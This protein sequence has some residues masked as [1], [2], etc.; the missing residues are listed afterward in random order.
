[1]L[2]KGKSVLKPFKTVR[3]SKKYK[4]EYFY[5]LEQFIHAYGDQEL[6]S[7]F[8]CSTLFRMTYETLS[9]EVVYLANRLK[10]IVRYIEPKTREMIAF[11]IND[12]D[13]FSDKI[14]FEEHLYNSAILE[15]NLKL[16][17]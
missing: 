11:E 8:N 15:L 2:V 7:R 6:A 5:D 16:V 14:L 17:Q 10:A 13:L 9:I 1:M 4:T 3:K 12:P